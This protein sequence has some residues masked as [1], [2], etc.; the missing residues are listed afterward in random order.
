MALETAMDGE[1]VLDLSRLLS[2]VLH[3]TPT[4][5]DRVEMAYARGLAEAM[6]DRLHF[7]AVHPSGF[8]GR[9]PRRA[10]A[11]FLDLTEERWEHRGFTSIWDCV[12]SLPEPSPRCAR[13]CHAAMRGGGGRSIFRRRP[14]IWSGNGRSAGSSRMNGRAS[15]V[16]C[17]T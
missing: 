12:A 10:V 5:V 3:P 1:I 16:W 8:Y 13:D 2:R 15:S 11:R 6:P 17:T 9:L 7:A 4:G 14:T